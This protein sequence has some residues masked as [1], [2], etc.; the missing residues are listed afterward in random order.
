MKS[1]AN[2]ESRDNNAH[3]NGSGI[4]TMEE[5]ASLI[6]EGRLDLGYSCDF[7][8]ILN[9]N[10]G[11]LEANSLAKATTSD[12]SIQDP[13]G[14]SW[15]GSKGYVNFNGG[16]FRMRDVDAA[17]VFDNAL[18]RI[19]V[20][21]GGATI[22][23]NGRD[24]TLDYPLE[25]PEGNGVVSIDTTGLLDREWVGSPYIAIENVGDSA[26]YGATVYADFDSTTRRVTGVHV[27][28]PGCNY[29]AAQ[30][31]IHYGV[32]ACFTNAV[33]LGTSASGGLTKTGEG[34][35]TL[36]CAN[37]F[38]GAV[39]VEAGTLKVNA[40]GALPASAPVS[41]AAGA[42]LDLNGRPMAA[43]SLGA[44]GGS[45]KN[46]TLTL[47]NALT[48]DLA[49]A[50]AG[51]GISYAEGTFRFPKGASVTLTNTGVRD[52]KDRF[53]TLFKVTDEG[54]LEGT[55]TL[56][57]DDLSPWTLVNTGRELRLAF[58]AGTVLIFR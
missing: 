51:K 4:L 46:G 44:A 37:T 24:R 22:D 16:T 54:S 19:T 6:Q 42:T 25:A 21:A 13:D 17:K 2:V 5:G 32:L 15:R 47:P 26:G 58:P 52:E 48:F 9:L 56:V 3:V 27:V 43:T 40:D 12:T 31:V 7:T 55:P 28:S 14:F 53:Y 35:L 45:V 18:N 20:F 38:T 34:T 39:A 33:T 36:N 8:A 50:K 41:V 49:A 1:G 23:T 10:G 11:V 29:T 30:A 57:N